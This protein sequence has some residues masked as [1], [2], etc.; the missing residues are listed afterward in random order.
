[1][2][3]LSFDFF[4][5]FWFHAAIT[6]ILQSL[7]KLSVLQ[8]YGCLAIGRAMGSPKPNLNAVRTSKIA[9]PE[10]LQNALENLREC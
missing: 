2:L 9:P 1:M 10:R 6:E 4:E 5:F 7:S 8:G 3:R